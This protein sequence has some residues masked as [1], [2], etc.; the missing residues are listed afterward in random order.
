MDKEDMIYIY[1]HTQMHTHKMKYYSA[2]KKNYVLSLVT[3]WI[4]LE[5][6]I[7][8]KRNQRKTNPVWFHLYV[9]SQK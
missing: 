6:V 1:T 9:K 8:S 7:L 2:I 4:D 3:T 5:G